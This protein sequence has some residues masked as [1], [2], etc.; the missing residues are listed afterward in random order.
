VAS[1]Y[2]AELIIPA[3][4][5]LKIGSKPNHNLTAVEVREAVIYARDSQ[6]GWVEDEE[7]GRRLMVTGTTYAG[8]LVIAYMDPLNENDE[9]EGTFVLRTAMTSA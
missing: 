5:E 2:V 3:A 1:V 4:V 8:R 7:H 9:E 6:A